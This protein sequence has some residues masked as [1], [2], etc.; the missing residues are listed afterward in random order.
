[1]NITHE[2]WLCECC[3]LAAVNGDSCQCEEH[4]ADVTRGLDR[5][6]KDFGWLSANWDSETGEGIKEFSWRGCDCCD[7]NRNKG[8]S[9]H[10]FAVLG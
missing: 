8:G 4:D 7:T 9:L 1:M 5:L 10:R 3:M 6:S 2:F